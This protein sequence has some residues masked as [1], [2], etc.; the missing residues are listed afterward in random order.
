MTLEQVLA[1]WRGDAAVVRKHGDK[2]TAD[3]IER[4]C[5]AVARAAEDFLVWLG[6][7]DAILRSGHTRAWLRG[8]FAQWESQGH[9]KHVNRRR[10]YRQLV[11]PRRIDLDAARD[12]ARRTARESAA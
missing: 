8:R 10:Y 3:V 2:H 7:D 4:L 11:V 1:D 12:D 6:E 5:D 9:A